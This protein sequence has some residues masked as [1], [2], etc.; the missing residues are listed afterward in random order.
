MRLT[1]DGQIAKDYQ[2]AAVAAVWMGQAL[3]QQPVNTPD[4]PWQMARRSVWT[5]GRGDALAGVTGG[6]NVLAA[7]AGGW[8]RRLDGPQPVLTG[9]RDWQPSS[10]RVG[11]GALLADTAVVLDDEMIVG[12]VYYGGIPAGTF[13]RSN[14]FGALR[15]SPDGRLA[16]WLEFPGPSVVLLDLTTGEVLPV[17]TVGGAC[18]TPIAFV[19]QGR[20]WI[21][22][23]TDAMGLVFHP[24]DDASYGYQCGVPQS[25]YD[26]DVIPWHG[27]VVLGWSRDPGQFDTQTLTIPVLGQGM[28]PLVTP[29]PPVPPVPPIPPIP[30][31]PP[32]PPTMSDRLMS[33]N[34]KY[35]TIQQNDGNFVTY[36]V[37][38]NKSVWASGYVE[39]NTPP[40]EPPPVGDAPWET[41]TNAELLA[42]NGRIQ[43]MFWSGPYGFRPGQPN[44]ALFTAQYDNP[45][46]SDM[47]RANMRLVGQSYAM[48]HWPIGPIIQKGYHGKY[49]DTNFVNNFG[50]FK[51][52]VREL[53][54]GSFYPCI[55]L[56]DDTGVYADGNGIN[57]DAV[58]RDLTPLYTQPDFQA[59]ARIVMPAWE[60]DNWDA[61]TWQWASDYMA[62]VF[63][64]ALRGLHFP[65]GKGAPGRHSDLES[66]AYP[67][68][69]ALW[70]AVIPKLH[71]F[72]Q[73]ETYQFGGEADWLT[74]GRTAEQQFVYDL[75]DTIRRFQYGTGAEAG[76][77]GTDQ[78]KA[79][80][81]ATRGESTKAYNQF[82]G[83]YLTACADGQPL[84]VVCFE[85]ASYYLG[86]PAQFGTPEAVM[87]RRDRFAALAATVECLAGIGD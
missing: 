64:N 43:T 55:F 27:G 3:F 70:N 28:V 77:R 45:C 52:A 61:D 6:C 24:A 41:T 42:W 53:W 44:N 67:N 66:G 9:S 2:G 82:D 23:Q 4:G 63:P 47:D 25:I 69:A 14:P 68:E 18:Y 11:D 1:A 29:E 16:I 48:K 31:I 39:D 26:P 50:A 46:F 72:C 17:Q 76:R 71:F 58:E 83:S 38:D 21:G 8:M 37:S 65:T 80:W 12:T 85:Y 35:R 81:D 19:F 7:C 32:E 74:D 56:F 30:P 33:Q 49:P 79:Q 36:R 86:N 51:G 20:S 13:Q 60:P 5:T 57:R 84:R 59:M 40:P 78:Q 10:G 87:A 73:Q 75:L 62:R 15:L 22:Y 34:G 54:L